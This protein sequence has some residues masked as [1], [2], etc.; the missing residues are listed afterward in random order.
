MYDCRTT[1]MPTGWNR[2]DF[3]QRLIKWRYKMHVIFLPQQGIATNHIDM[4]ISSRTQ[5]SLSA[6]LKAPSDAISSHSLPQASITSSS[7]VNMAAED[8]VLTENDLD[9]DV[10]GTTEAKLLVAASNLKCMICLAQVPS[11]TVV[12]LSCC[13]NTLCTYHALGLDLV[14][15]C[16]LKPKYGRC[17]QCRKTTL[18]FLDPTKAY[19]ISQLKVTCP[20]QG[21]TWSNQRMDWV[22]HVNNCAHRVVVCTHAS[23][24]C[25]T[26]VKNQDLTAHL[27]VC[28]YRPWECKACSTKTTFQ[29]R[30]THLDRCPRR[31]IPCSLCSVSMPGDQVAA[32]AERC[33][34]MLCPGECGTKIRRRDKEE[35]LLSES[36]WRTHVVALEAGRVRALRDL[37]S[38]TDELCALRLASASTVQQQLQQQQT[39][40]SRSSPP[41][42]PR[43]RAF[44]AI[45]TPDRGRKRTRID[46]RSRTITREEESDDDESSHGS[47]PEEEDKKEDEEEDDA[48]KEEAEEAAKDSDKEESETE[49]LDRTCSHCGVSLEDPDDDLCL[50]CARDA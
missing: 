4:S 27:L 46:G 8:V 11:G 34:W 28:D 13:H 37:Q 23:A 29:Q 10:H 40:A 18:P 2:F 16:T 49:S 44:T 5:L 50:Y 14:V 45:G 3:F 38:K 30:Q 12:T 22:K 43:R 9:L 17:P 47:E 21:C 19:I 6:E 24:G 35:H 15:P 20:R 1:R 25:R 33:E 42:A 32:H 39:S 36:L 26:R 7:S 41:S 31:A 48:D